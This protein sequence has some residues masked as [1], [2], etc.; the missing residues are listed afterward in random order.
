[1]HCIV[2]L[3]QNFIL[4]IKYLSKASIIFTP[5]SQKVTENEVKYK[6]RNCIFLNYLNYM[7]SDDILTLTSKLKK[8]TLNS[9]LSV[10]K[11]IISRE[12]I[13]IIV[14]FFWKYPTQQ[15]NNSLLKLLTDKSK[16]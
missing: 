7:K 13:R 3:V 2:F 16:N 15:T 4:S 1:M 6:A 11:R 14:F 12:K 9:M 5:Y 10:F 8:M